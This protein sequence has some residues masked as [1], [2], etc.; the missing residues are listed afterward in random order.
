MKNIIT[1]WPALFILLFA[2]LPGYAAVFD[3]NDET[4][5]NWTYTIQTDEDR[6][7]VSE[8]PVGWLDINSFPSPART[9]PLGDSRGS[10]TVGMNGASLGGLNSAEEYYILSFKSADLSTDADWQYIDSFSTRILP[11]FTTSEGGY[12]ANVIIHVYD[13]DEGR[14]RFFSSGSATEL[15]LDVWNERGFSDIGD[16]FSRVSPP[17]V[18]YIVTGITVNIWIE[19]IPGDLVFCVDEIIPGG[20]NTP[21]GSDVDVVLGDATVTFD[22]VA[23][24][25][26]TTITQSNTGESLPINFQDSCTPPVYYNIETTATVTG[27][28]EICIQYD[29]TFCN[30][31]N[32]QLLHNEDGTWVDR[33]SSVD[34]GNNV[35]CATVSHLSAF[36]LASPVTL[37]TVW[38]DDDYSAFGTNDGHKWGVDAFNT[39][40]AGIDSIDAPGRVYVKHGI[41]AENIVLKSQV[42]VIGQKSF[43]P[44]PGEVI[45]TGGGLKKKPIVTAVN[46]DATALLQGVSIKNGD[47]TN[48]GGMYCNNSYLTVSK[49]LFQNNSAEVGAGMFNSDAY[50]VVQNCTFKENTA[51]DNGGGI[52]NTGGAPTVKNCAF[53][54][55]EA[56]SSATY[57]SGGGGVYNSYSSAEIINC[58]FSENSGGN[59]GGGIYN[60]YSSAARI[61]DCDFENNTAN[62]GGAIILYH[63]SAT[64]TGCLFNANNAAGSGQGGGMILNNASPTIRDSRF[65]ANTAY[66]GAGMCNSHSS[67]IVEN[68]IFQENS[69]L[70]GSGMLN[71]NKSTPSVINC[72]FTD[73]TGLVGAGMHND[74]SSPTVINATFSN[75]GAPTAQNGGAMYNYNS[76][77]PTVSNCIFWADSPNEIYTDSSSSLDMTFSN[78]QDG[79]SCAGCISQDPLF[80]DPGNQN[81]H[82]QAASPCIDQGDSSRVNPPYTDFEGDA[83]I[84]DGDDNGSVVVDMGADEFTASLA[85]DFDN[86]KDVDGSDISKFAADYTGSGLGEFA[87]VFGK[88]Y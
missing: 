73:N 81:Y 56:N 9:D 67:P 85:G 45:I 21:V 80:V 86:D 64:V 3:F 74:D 25:G 6:V 13:E 7:L 62:D 82:L 75:N 23:T 44:K 48:G 16:L 51:S 61:T 30:E 35:I 78:S 43:Y 36:V 60:W 55:N 32:I 66:S 70:G 19:E 5:Q 27:D 41:Y 65:I 10:A 53:M 84:I 24:S 47:Y 11:S 69:S 58:T 77:S 29:D 46:V 42:Q 63:S 40:Q 33:T 34:T 57:Y 37:S 49:C 22:N 28:I 71:K 50:V 1:R 8:R 18:N 76:S 31:S 88:I 17:L 12:Y 20:G 2:A 83:R 38:V 4:N 68:C 54:G 14:D 72:L 15:N 87:A 39:I 59:A 52:Y 26:H 79:G